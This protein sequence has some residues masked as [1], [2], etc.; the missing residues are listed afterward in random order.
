MTL[1]EQVIQCAI[2]NGYSPNKDT[3]WIIFIT[4]DI[5]YTSV[6]FSMWSMW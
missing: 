4:S 1:E 2:D 3:I 5:I 6:N